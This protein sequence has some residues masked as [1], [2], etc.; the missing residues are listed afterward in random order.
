MELSAAYLRKKLKDQKVNIMSAVEGNKKEQEQETTET[1]ES[2]DSKVKVGDLYIE[3]KRKTL[4]TQVVLRNKPSR[5]CSNVTYLLWGRG[6]I[7]IFYRF[8]AIF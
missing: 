5:D 6:S 4:N 3:W 2:E 8:T 7:A 1:R